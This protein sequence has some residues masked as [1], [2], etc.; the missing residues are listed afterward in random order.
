LKVKGNLRP[1][2]KY[3]FRRAMKG[4][5]PQQ[6]L[7]QPKAGFA[8]PIDYW[9]ARDLRGMVDDLLC[10]SQVRR[11]G[12]LRPA[13]V[14]GLIEQHRRGTHDCSMQIWQLL[15][16]ELWMQMFLDGGVQEMFSGMETLHLAD[17][18]SEW[19]TQEPGYSRAV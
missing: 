19:V 2:T 12:L 8:A 11:R 14:R 6:V 3:I 17:T 1:T 7:K 15:T 18:R 4:I 5:V 10:E 13:A 9:L 16:L